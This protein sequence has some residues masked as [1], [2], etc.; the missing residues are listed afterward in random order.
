M[1]N[2]GTQKS[3]SDVAEPPESCA[4]KEHERPCEVNEKVMPRASR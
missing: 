1:S 4:A 3:N 2:D